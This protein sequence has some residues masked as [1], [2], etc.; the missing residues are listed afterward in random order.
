[1][2]PGPGMAG[3]P[4]PGAPAC[5]EGVEGR[6]EAQDPA[7]GASAFDSAPSMWPR[8]PLRLLCGWIVRA[9]GL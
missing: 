6:R 3:L 7:F 8:K 5:A 2:G 4:A 1:M 9:R